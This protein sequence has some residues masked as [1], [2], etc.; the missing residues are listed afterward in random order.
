M[1]LEVSVPQQHNVHDTTKHTHRKHKSTQN[2]VS[3]KSQKQ[4]M[5]SEQMWMYNVKPQTAEYTHRE[6][7]SELL[8]ITKKMFKRAT[9]MEWLVNN[10][11]TQ[12][13]SSAIPPY[14]DRNH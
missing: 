4:R 2:A 11:T 10:N 13:S 6:N 3:K 8:Y 12:L 7:L 1:L 5:H 14:S 9:A